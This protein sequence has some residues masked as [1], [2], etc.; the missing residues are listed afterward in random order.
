MAYAKTSTL[1]MLAVSAAILAGCSS[2]VK[3]DEVPV[4]TRTPVATDAAAGNKAATASQSGVATVD[5][6]AKNANANAMAGTSLG[7]VVYFDFDSFSVKDEFRPV[8]EGHAKALVGQRS[9]RIVVEGHTDERGGREYNLAL[10][11]KRAEAVQRSLVLLGATAEQIEAVSYG[12]ERPAANGSSEDAW[13]KNR[14]AE[15]K[16]R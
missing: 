10:G 14:R 13:A 15:L 4:E 6:N 16:D 7:R 5:L 2:S 1:V 3:L 9:K 8:V 12:E 11:Q